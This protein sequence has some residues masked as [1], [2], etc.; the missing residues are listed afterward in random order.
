M[1]GLI[2]VIVATLALVL[3]WLAGILFGAPWSAILFRMGLAGAFFVFADALIA[4]GQ[5]K[6]GVLIMP[7]TLL[8]AAAVARYLGM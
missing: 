7:I 2:A 1:R 3:L 5:L 4:D 8:V 6:N